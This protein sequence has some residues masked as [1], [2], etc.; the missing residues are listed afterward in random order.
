LKN[1]I[2]NLFYIIKKNPRKYLT[3]QKNLKSSKHRQIAD[4]ISGMTDR[5]AINL[6]N[7]LK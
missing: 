7:N 4:F 5:Y 3:T 1:I 2:K 6:Y